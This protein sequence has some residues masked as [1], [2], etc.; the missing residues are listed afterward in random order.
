MG[1]HLGEGK[2]LDE[3]LSLL[4]STAEGVATAAAAYRLVEQLE[5][6]API[7]RAVYRVLYEGKKIED[8]VVSILGRSMK[9]EFT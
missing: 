8:A 7:I 9:P 2:S 4:G 3:A 6:D 5:I 1:Q